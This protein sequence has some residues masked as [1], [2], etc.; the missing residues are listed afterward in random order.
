MDG[1]GRS[2]NSQPV[3]PNAATRAAQPSTCP[4]GR[5]VESDGYTKEPDEVDLSIGPA[6]CAANPATIEA[7]PAI[8]SGRCQ[9]WRLESDPATGLYRRNRDGTASR[10]PRFRTRADV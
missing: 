10:H 4:F 7:D 5:G 3:C 6:V 8:A 9:S 2:R 1:S